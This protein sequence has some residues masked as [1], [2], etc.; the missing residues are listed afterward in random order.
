MAVTSRTP[1][2]ILGNNLNDGVFNQNITDV[3]DEGIGEDGISDKTG[4]GSIT[5]NI[6]VFNIS[7][8]EN[9]FTTLV[10]GDV[11]T[12]NKQLRIS[13]ADIAKENKRIEI[14]KTGFRNNSE[15]YI[16][17]MIAD[18]GPI[19][20]NPNINQPLGIGTKD[21]VLTKYRNGQIVGTP[22]SIK[23]NTSVQLNFN[24][25]KGGDEYE[26]PNKYTVSFNITGNG[27]PVSI[28]KN[29]NRNS[30]FFP[31][32]G[33]T[34]YEDVG[35][36]IY[37][38]RSS[39]ITLYRIANI[40]YTLADTQQRT[41]SANAGESLEVKVSLNSDYIFDITVEDVSQGTP[42]KD[43]QIELVRDSAREYNINSN[44]GVPLMFRK[45]GD[46]E[47]ITVIVG[48]DVLEFDDLDKGDLCG[49]TIP[50]SVFKN[51]GKYNVKI[52]P[53]SFD[54]YENQVRP[55][56]P[57]DRIEI[58]RE[59]IEYNVKEEVVIE[60]P[61]PKDIYNPYNPVVGGGTG[62]GGARPITIDPIQ[63]EL[64]RR[65]RASSGV[66]DNS[67]VNRPVDNRNFR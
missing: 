30:E 28:L 37:T 67:F 4:G 53:F 61:K 44:A 27:S 36:T 15:Y 12:N 14:K 60:T 39:D 40:S 49:I 22:I 6:F 2:E 10:N 16:V 66:E 29:G 18:G 47:S 64:Q 54:D 26:E 43:P 32:I 1:D 13:R 20:N 41:L 11:V 25:T 50:H 63:E 59:K 42:T 17:E 24:L 31:T 56:E 46:V 7:S 55:A 8:N 23:N 48:E 52:F 21:V 38:I 5:S 3:F 65:E 34:Q 9:S 35:G 57:A 51:I 58:K 45:N 33:N 62:G 19:I